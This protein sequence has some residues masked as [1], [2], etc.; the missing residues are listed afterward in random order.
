MHCGAGPSI[1]VNNQ[2]A[3]AEADIAAI[4]PDV[5][6]FPGHRKGLMAELTLQGTKITRIH[7]Q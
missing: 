6:A 3:G 4:T 5:Y 7:P 2:G 1:V